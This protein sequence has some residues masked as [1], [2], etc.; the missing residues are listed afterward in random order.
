MVL[1]SNTAVVSHNSCSTNH[2]SPLLDFVS[3][4]EIALCNWFLTVNF[5][6]ERA[7]V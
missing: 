6:M 1:R 2:I 5:A 4:T 3:L 7:Q